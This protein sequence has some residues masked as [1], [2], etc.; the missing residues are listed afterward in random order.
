MKRPTIAILA[1][2]EGTTA[3]AVIRASAQ[4]RTLPEI[5]LVISNNASAGIF[6]RVEALNQQYDLDIKTLHIGGTTHPAGQGEKVRPGDQTRAEEE[7]ILQ[8]LRE[9]G[10]DL[11][12]LLGYMKRVGKRLVHEF[13]W[14]P[15]YTTAHEAKM[16]NTHP[17][18]LPETK[19]LYGA[20]VQ[21]HVLK[22][23]L[24]HGGQTLH[25]V[26]EDYD[27]GPVIAEHKVA[28]K[29]DDTPDSLFDRVKLAEKKHLP[30]DLE[31]FLTQG[32]S[33]PLICEWS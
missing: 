11:I 28:V 12:V 22:K 17:G 24:S 10:F 13:G 5:G 16:I 6:K 20:H 4:G 32:S 14:R 30:E 25:V 3:E 26:G 27:E 29:A 31:A 7:A 9:G 23:G 21:E 15:E 19:G 8:A 33:E 18:L 1:S 2:G